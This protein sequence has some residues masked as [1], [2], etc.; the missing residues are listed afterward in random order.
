MYMLYCFNETLNF[1]GLYSLKSVTFV[2]K[3]LSLF[4]FFFINAYAHAQNAP[5]QDCGS[6][7]SVCQSVYTQPN[8]YVGY[9]DTSEL[10]AAN[11][12]CL[13]SGENNTVWYIINVSSNGTLEFT[14]TPNTL[15]DDYDWAVWDATGAG[16]NAVATNP[17][18][19]CNYSGQSGLTGLSPTATNPS[20]NAGGPPFSTTINAV[21]GETYI[22]VVD[23]FSGSQSGYTLDFSASTASIY[24]TIPPAFLSANTKCNLESDTLKI[25]LSE[26]ITCASIAADGSDFYLTPTVSG[27]VPIQ[28]YNLNCGTATFVNEVTVI[29]SGVIPA[30]NYWLHS[31]TGSDGNTLIDNCGNQQRTSDSLQFT[32]NPSQLSMVQLDTPACIGARVVLSRPI[33]CNTVA[34]DG[35]DF[36]VSGSSVVEIV[37]ATPFNCDPVYDLT[38]TIDL[39]F[40]TSIILPGTYTLGMKQGTDGNMILD[41]C[42]SSVSNTISWEVSDKGID[43]F[44]EPN[45]ICNPDYIMLN[46]AV[47]FP[48]SPEGYNYAWTPATFIDDSTQG[49][50]M[51]YVNQST[52]FTLQILDADYC[53]RRDTAGLFLSVRNPVFAYVADTERCV[54]QP[55][56]FLL[57]GGESYYWYPSTALSCMDCPNPVANPQ[58]TTTY[59]AVITDQYNCSDTLPKTIIVYPLP[60]INAGGDTT[61]YYG[62]MAQLYTN[63]DL[64]AVYTWA[65]SA[66]LDYPNNFNPKASPQKTTTYIVTV[67][68]IH[69]CTNVDSVT[70]VVRDDIPVN[71]PTAFTPNG[72]GKNDIFHISSPR[73]QK[74]QEFKVYNRWGQVVFS[75]TDV[76]KGWDGSYNGAPQDMG[77]YSYV[78]KAVFPDGRVEIYK[79]DITLVR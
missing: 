31:Q 12:D 59:Y 3:I 25:R 67:K 47:G 27:V 40:D 42:G 53:F 75:T 26:P 1:S 18:V 71:I 21:A 15:T 50:T 43:A 34:L 55:V 22:L 6:A 17:P 76:A 51:A 44:T 46:S 13:S 79:G 45:L 2:K 74:L 68:D 19:R 20:E 65:P 24:D 70:V 58:A 73:F 38:N 77:V 37:S 78:I 61:I 48:P 33:R 10:N 36:T 49:M 28:A 66:S 39:K 54:N 69:N 62:E 56:E 14:I 11:Q 72:D 5:E 30:G 8:S 63:L 23:N 57:S 52:V 35:S 9:G 4:V 60:V 41:T 32:V 16:C 29:F 64:P 7:L